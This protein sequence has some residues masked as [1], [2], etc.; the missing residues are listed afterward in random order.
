MEGA[1]IKRLNSMARI[2]LK[3]R[4]K[5]KFIPNCITKRVEI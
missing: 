5:K 2:M 4:A 3:G 1:D